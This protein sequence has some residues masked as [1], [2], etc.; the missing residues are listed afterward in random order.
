M[1]HVGLCHHCKQWC[2]LDRKSWLPDHDMPNGERCPDSRYS[3]WVLKYELEDAAEAKTL[4]QEIVGDI[5]GCLRDGGGH[6]MACGDGEQCEA[7]RLRCA[8]ALAAFVL[9]EL[10]GTK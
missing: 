3:Y 4:A 9:A 1:K 7:E 6:S 2:N 5:G 10:W 8:Q